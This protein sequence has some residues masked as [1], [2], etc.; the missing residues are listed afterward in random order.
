MSAF[1]A[2]HVWEHLS[3]HDAHRATRNCF[4][5]LRPGGR[6]RL[7]VPDPAWHNRG[8]ASVAATAEGGAPADHADVPQS[9]DE[10]PATKLADSGH[11]SQGEYFRPGNTGPADRVSGQG[12][13]TSGAAGGG[14]ENIERLPAWLSA[15]MLA[16]DI[17]DGHL[18]QYTPE[19]LANVCWSAG[20]TPILVEGRQGRAKPP[21][22]TTAEAEEHPGAT[23]RTPK[24]PGTSGVK[25]NGAWT[26]PGVDVDENADARLWGLV[27]RYD[28]EKGLLLSLYVGAAHR[29]DVFCKALLLGDALPALR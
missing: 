20:F 27:R 19:L 21:A 29:G 11:R 23:S 7:A 5:N 3:L 25:V 8:L 16:G 4:R 1:S 9:A 28:S 26:G 2:E 6:L 22:A 17:R 10:V 24:M 14:R 18:V 15:D 12:R 13:A